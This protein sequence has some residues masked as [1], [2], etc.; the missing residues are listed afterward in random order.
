VIEAE[1]EVAMPP[2]NIP[3]EVP[4][5]GRPVLPQGSASAVIDLTIDDPC[6]DKGK[7]KVDIEIVNASDWP[8]APVAPEDD[9]AEAS[10]RWPNFM[11]LA[12]VRSE[13]GLFF[14]LDDK[15]E[16]QHWEYVEG[17][18]KHSVQSLWMVT[19]TLVRGMSEAFEV[20]G[21]CYFIWLIPPFVLVL[22]M[23]LAMVRS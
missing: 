17:L 16:V 4:T 5:D 18:H 12:L 6:S 7:Q 20:S 22:T 19:D 2:P 14:A 21:V 23:S 11:E 1:W 3:V 9:T 15:D 13:E 10:G 8:E